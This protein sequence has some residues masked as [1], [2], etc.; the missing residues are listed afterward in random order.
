MAPHGRLAL[1][2]LAVLVV[3]LPMMVMTPGLVPVGRML[4]LGSVAFAV[5]LTET[6]AGVVLL[7]AAMLLGPA[8]VFAALLWV[9]AGIAMRWSR[10]AWAV[11]V[12]L[13]V[14]GLLVPIYRTPFHPSVARATL[15]GV[16]R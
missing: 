12:G 8:V 4:Q 14:L 9:L 13:L 2:L 3:P 10:V 11:A 16:Y 6:T 15:L 1:W 7:L 5:A